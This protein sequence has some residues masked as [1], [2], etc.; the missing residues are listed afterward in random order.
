M[1]SNEFVSKYGP[2][3]RVTGAS[4]GIGLAVAHQLAELGLSIVLVS[5]RQ[6]TLEQLAQGHGANGGERRGG[7]ES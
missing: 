7:A 5:R 6:A 4:S 1:D 3:A 2:R